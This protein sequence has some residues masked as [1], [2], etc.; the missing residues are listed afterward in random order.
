VSRHDLT[1]RAGGVT[2]IGAAVG[3]SL[4]LRG[5]MSGP[6]DGPTLLEVALL[7]ASFVLALSGAVMMLRGG[8]W[9][10]PPREE[11]A[12][13]PERPGASPDERTALADLL[14]ERGRRRP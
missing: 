13:F 12:P 10:Q 7:L 8:R 6:G 5:L 1:V 4:W 9:L 2:L 11:V 3:A 14:V